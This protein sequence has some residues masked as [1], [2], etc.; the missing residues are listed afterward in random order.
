MDKLEI[1]QKREGDELSAR[2]WNSNV[3]K[4]NEIID[5]LN[6]SSSVQRKIFVQNNLNSK[7]LAAQAGRP[8]VLNF[9]YVSQERYSY[10]EPYENTGERGLCTVWVKNAQYKDFTQVLQYNLPSAII[11]QL[12]VAEYLTSGVNQVMITVLGEITRETTPSYVYNVQLTSLGIEAPNFRWWQAYGGSILFPL[13][14]SGNISKKLHVSI[15]GKTNNYQTEY[16]VNLGTATYVETAYNYTI[17]HP[18]AEGVYI[19]KAWLSN[20]DDTLQTN[21]VSFEIMCSMP[22]STHKLVAINNSAEQLA[23]W[24]ENTAFDFAVYDGLATSTSATFTV[25]KDNEVVFSSVENAIPTGTK[26]TFS[27]PMDIETDDDADFSVEIAILDGNNTQLVEPLTLEVENT[28]GY[29]AVAGAVFYMNPKTRSNNQADRE[30]IINEVDKT[31][32]DATWLNM[33]W[34]NDGWK[35]DAEGNRLLRILSGSRCIMDYKPFAKE[36]ARTG[37]TIELD[38][39]AYNVIDGSKPIIDISTPRGDSFVGLKVAPEEISM[40]SQSER[41]ETTQNLPVDSEVRIRL[42]MTIMPEAYGNAGFNISCVYV[43]SIKNRV[44]NYQS[45]DYFEHPAMITIGSDMADVDVYGIRVYDRGLTSEG[46]QKNYISWLAS[47]AQKEQELEINDVLDSAGKEVDFFNTVDQYNCFV[48]DK[49]FPRLSNSSEQEG[50]LEVYFAGDTAPYCTV[51]NVKCD[52]QGTSSKKYYEWNMRFRVDKAP[53]SVTTYANGTT[54]KQLIDLFPGIT[55]KMSRITAKKN[56]ASSMQDHKAGSVNAYDSLAKKLG[57]S[58]PAID[59]DKKVRV[60]VYQEPFVGFSKQLNEDGQWVYTCM[61]LFTMGPDKGDKNCFGYDT[62]QYPGLIAIEGA[63]N[64][65]LLTLFRV[66]W[67]APYVAY[68]EGEEAFQYNGANAWDFNGGKESN[69]ATWIPAYNLVYSCS[70]RIKSYNGTLEQLNADV[71]NYRSTG[72]EYWIAKTGDSNLYNLYYYEASQERFIASNTEE[73]GVTPVNLRNQLVGKG[74][75]LTETNLQ[76]KTN[77]ELNQLF[78]DA[79]VEKFKQEAGQYFDIDDAVYHS[80]FIEFVA[81]TDNRAKNTYAYNFGTGKWKWRQ[82]DLDTIFPIDNQGQDKKPYWVETHDL[83]D[84]GANVWN[85]ETSNFWNLLELA[86]P[87]KIETGMRNML[88]AMEELGEGSGTSF[89]RLYAFYAN[90]YLGVK[91]YFPSTLFNADA[92]RYEDA[93]VAYLKGD[94]S[95]D[96]DPITQSH[97]DFYSAETAWLKKRILYIMSKY[98]YGMFS[99]DG[100]DIISVRTAGNEI[101]YNLV[102]AI[103][104]YPA[105]ASGTSIKRG[106]RTMAGKPCRM[107]INLA[108][109]GDQQNSIQGASWLKSI[110]QW[111][112][113]NVSGTMVVQGR[114]LQEI[115]LGHASD[116]I[117]IS[118]TGLSI[119]NC[120]SARL[121][122]LRRIKTLSGSINLSDCVHLEEVYAEGTS[123]SQIRLPEGGGLRAIG[124]PANNAYL[125]LRN[126]PVLESSRVN[127]SLCSENITDFFVQDCAKINPIDMLISVME[128]QNVQ[129]GNHELKRVRAVGFDATYRENGS[130]V[131]DMLARLASGE[132]SGLNAE[133]IAGDD[134]YPVLDGKL[135][136]YADVYEDSVETLRRVF[137]KLT[138]NVIGEYYVRFEDTVVGEYFIDTFGNGVGIKTYQ[139]G[140]I[141]NNQ[142]GKPFRANTQ[143]KSFDEMRYMTRLTEITPESFLNCTSLESITIPSRVNIINYAAF[144]NTALERLVIPKEVESIWQEAFAYNT[145]LKE[146]VFEQGSRLTTLRWTMFQYSTKLERVELPDTVTSKGNHMFNGCTSLA[147][148]H[149]PNNQFIT[150]IE[151][152]DFRECT[153]LKAMPLTPYITEIKKNAFRESGLVEIDF[154]NTNVS[155][156]QTAAFFACRSVK[157]LVFNSKITSIPYECF[158]RMSALEELIIPANISFADTYAFAECTSL[159]KVDLPATLTNI[160]ASTFDGNEKLSTLIV[161][162]VTPPTLGNRALSGTN[163]SFMIYVPDASVNTYK[164]ASGWSSYASRIVGLSTL[165]ANV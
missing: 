82:D 39:K 86:F 109:A 128:A 13:L 136:I 142:Y 16:S 29:S 161:R 84:N 123:L 33:N 55:P 163:N 83:Y 54:E 46:V 88:S 51:T 62:K 148:C 89:D 23:N 115:T 22:V 124:F 120:P 106:E 2:E 14:I 67:K 73:G 58:N 52:G 143:I 9:T 111:H 45:N 96:T 8:C 122:D 59:A 164:A 98:S 99:A 57:L 107:V 105:I 43:D 114:R 151:E 134:T 97:G 90:Y 48:F 95:N 40:F 44:F 129:G 66:P 153:S 110:G 160:P 36:S 34:G 118:I 79:R 70:P 112:D 1:L 94:Y 35:N 113:K 32:V 135:T 100:T 18:Q 15:Q 24:T 127:L 130:Y 104:M 101:T 102:P 71:V 80:N 91:K 146:I 159:K 132:Y 131:L 17:P 92:K 78:I 116:P 81:G 87:E 42:T 74:Y 149:Y 147:F 6:G 4:I 77:E 47:N 65:P 152:G 144:R 63:D 156:L 41:D 140:E 103:A 75:G 31:P 72:Y 108:G 85:G 10:S 68:N 126:F 150:A 138:L 119:S 27:F 133:G 93:K 121:I 139:M 145:K 38:L 64:A 7:N 11:H 5:I 3:D 141:T 154:T 61:G 19:V 49:T 137:P 69:I 50:T 76:G 26:Q 20:A 155:I 125:L 56:W 12:D 25:K 165:P 158:R 117:T 28:A 21:A 162:A 37:K 157:S 30:K 53:G 60:A